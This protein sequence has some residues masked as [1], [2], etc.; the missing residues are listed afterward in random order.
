MKNVLFVIGLLIISLTINAQ[1]KTS[2]Q[3]IYD[4]IP[5]EIKQLFPKDGSMIIFD[6]NVKAIFEKH[7]EALQKLEYETYLIAQNT[8]GPNNVTL[9]PQ[10]GPW[11]FRIFCNG[12]NCSYSEPCP[13]SGECTWQFGCRGCG[14][15]FLCPACGI[16][17]DYAI[18][19]IGLCY[20]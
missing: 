17:L 7:K 2:I 4:K 20:W 1:Q 15:G 19:Y 9:L 6:D 10:G 12:Y 11:R 18:C 13:I 8:K 3:K 16:P 14:T 5:Q